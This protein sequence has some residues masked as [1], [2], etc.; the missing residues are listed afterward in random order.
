MTTSAKTPAI[1]ETTFN[2]VSGL[3]GKIDAIKADSKANS[4]I[5]NSHKMS[6]YAE[7]VGAVAMDA[8]S[9]GKFVRGY[10]SK[11]KEALK[12]EGGIADATA[13]RLA[14]NSVNAVTLI[15][16]VCNRDLDDTFAG[17]NDFAA[18]AH[19]VLTVELGCTT[20]AKLVAKIKDMRGGSTDKVETLARKIVGHYGK[21]TNKDTGATSVNKKVFINGLS[22]D[23]LDAFEARIEELR[24]V[25]AEFASASA[26]AVAAEEAK[27]SENDAISAADD[28]LASA[29]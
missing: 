13:K 11:L 22:D 19:H 29:A 12:T 2:N 14:E 15:V 24:A 25:R 26:A 7:I 5:I 10:G 21:T 27:K 8:Q 4:A 23:E 9:N 6:A 20:E 16:Q 1:T 28:A 18:V 3:V 17:S